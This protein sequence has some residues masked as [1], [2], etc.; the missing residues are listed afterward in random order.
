[1]KKKTIAALSLMMVVCLSACSVPGI[2]TTGREAE[3]ESVEEAVERTIEEGVYITYRIVNEDPSKDDIKDTIKNISK[4]IKEYADYSEC[5]VEDDEI[6][7]G[8]ELDPEEYDVE[9]L[10]ADLGRS[11]ELLIL[12]E[13]N[14]NAWSQGEEY[15]AA[16]NGADVKEASAAM[17]TTPMGYN[18]Y[19]VS[20]EL[21]DDGTEKFAEFTKSNIYNTSYIVFDDE[22]I[23]A[24]LIN[25]AILNGQLCITGVDSMES[26]KKLASFILAGTLPLELE[27]VD[28]EI[29]EEEE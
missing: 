14:Y 26:A 8:I 5:F 4:R 25:D 11:G 23:M 6:I 29:V 10:A 12:D 17:T 2:P 21:T 1:M 28:Y 24:P 15:E 9:E 18:S 16:L 20:L 27:L 19:V 7:V 3:E 22:L 13:E